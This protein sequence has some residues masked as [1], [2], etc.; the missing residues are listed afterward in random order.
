[1]NKL[2]VSAAVVGVM[3]VTASVAEMPGSRLRTAAI[4]Q[5]AEMKNDAGSVRDDARKKADARKKGL[6]DGVKE[7]KAAAKE[8]KEAIKG[9]F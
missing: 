8:K 5:K 9:M 1:M 7:E 2:I 3:I 6:K 4:E